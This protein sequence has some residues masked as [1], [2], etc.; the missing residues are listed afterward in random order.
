MLAVIKGQLVDKFEKTQKKN[1]GTIQK[2]AK[3]LIYQ[4]A[5]HKAVEVGV[6]YDTFNKLD[7]T[8]PVSITCNIGA[9]ATNS[10]TVFL[11]AKEKDNF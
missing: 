9:F 3:A 6:T 7:K 8:K 11:Y 5:D 4:E 1:D 10:G 2:V